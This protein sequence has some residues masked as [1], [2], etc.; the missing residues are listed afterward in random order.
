MDAKEKRERGINGVII[1]KRPPLRVFWIE[2]S[3][4]DSVQRNSTFA[5]HMGCDPFLLNQN[6]QAV[7]SILQEFFTIFTP[8]LLFPTQSIAFLVV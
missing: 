3:A 2:D 1:G 8:V 5:I 4:C 7:A 6:L